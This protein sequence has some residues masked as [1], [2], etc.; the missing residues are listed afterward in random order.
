MMKSEP[1]SHARMRDKMFPPSLKGP[2]ARRRKEYEYNKRAL[3]LSFWVSVALV[4][5]IFVVGY[6][7]DDAPIKTGPCPK[8]IDWNKGA[9]V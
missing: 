7:F 4:I 2:I 9:V 3:S 6:G 8:V 1:M 5:A